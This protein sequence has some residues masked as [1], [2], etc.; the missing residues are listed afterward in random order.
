M[1]IAE[2]IK[3]LERIRRRHGDEVRIYFDCPHCAQ[4]F[5]P[6]KVEAVAVHVRGT[7]ADDA[8]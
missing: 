7:D 4:S 6:G 3:A 1:T 2:A 5:T 8:T